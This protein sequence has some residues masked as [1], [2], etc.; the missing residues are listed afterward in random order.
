MHQVTSIHIGFTWLGISM[1]GIQADPH[2]TIDA[3]NLAS[4][5]RAMWEHGAGISQHL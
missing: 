3:W 1:T 4:V 5:F 2:S